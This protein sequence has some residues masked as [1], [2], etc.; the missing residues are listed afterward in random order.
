MKKQ[1]LSHFTF[2]G[3]VSVCLLFCILLSTGLLINISYG[4]IPGE[5]NPKAMNFKWSQTDTSLALLNKDVIIWQYNFRKNGKP[6]FHPVSTPD[7]VPLTWK[8]PPDHAWHY[9]LW[10][11]WKKINDL[12]YWEEDRKTGQARGKTEVVAVSVFPHD[13]FSATIEMT[14]AYHPPGKPP[15]LTEKRSLFVTPPDEKGNYYIDW[16]STFTA[17]KE[18]VVLERTPIEGQKGGRRWGGYGTLACRIDTRSLKNIRFLDS[19]GRVDLDIHTKHTAWVDVSG[20]VATDSSKAAGITIFDHPDNPRHPPP[21]Y[22]IKDW[23]ESHQL[24]FA[25]MNPGFLYEKGFTLEPEKSLTLRY[26]IFVHQGR[27]AVEKLQNEFEK[28]IAKK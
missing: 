17:G 7:G 24:L 15:V 8:S 20:T 22:V 9:A 11:S 23:V 2:P 3:G 25:Y 6:Y 4:F 14:I 1:C 10:F 16:K 5:K 13:D 26:R 27:G 18:R 21:G 19:E 12:N 28:F